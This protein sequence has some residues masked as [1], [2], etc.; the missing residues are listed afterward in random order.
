MTFFLFPGHR[1]A[2]SYSLLIL[3]LALSTYGCQP[4]AQQASDAPSSDSLATR[5][6]ASNPSASDMNITTAY[7]LGQFEP[8]EDSRFVKVEAPFG[9]ANGLGYLRQEAYDAFLR[10]HEAAK[11]DNID[12]VILSPTRNFSRQKSIWEAKWTG[13]TK[14]GGMNLATDVPDPEER[15]LNILRYSSMPGTSRHHWG[16]DMDFN[17]F[18]NDYFK[19]GKGLKEYEWLLANAASFGFCQPYTAKGPERPDGYEEERWH[20]SY[21][22]LAKPLLAAYQQKV[23]YDS[24]KGFQGAEVAREIDV[25]RTHVLG[26][27]S[28]CK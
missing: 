9:R 19:S 2:A 16:T 6:L 18:E 28:A 20:W 26:V 11:A 10:M 23:P 22:P 21:M 15:A 17:A 25:I 14:V 5:S 8:A 4:A 7:L 27:N 12:L 24:I 1:A 13:S 3:L